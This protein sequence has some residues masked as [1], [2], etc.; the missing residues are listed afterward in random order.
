MRKGYDV[1]VTDK[2]R[3]RES[4]G[5]DVFFHKISYLSHF[6]DPVTVAIYYL[7]NVSNHCT[8]TLD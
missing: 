5:T 4:S 8:G 6:T 3:S 1:V 7:V 2:L